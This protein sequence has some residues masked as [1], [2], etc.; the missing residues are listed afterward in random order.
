MSVIASFGFVPVYLG[1]LVT[2][3]LLQQAGRSLVATSSISAASEPLQEV[4]DAG[5]R[6]QQT[7][8]ARDRNSAATEVGG[9][10]GSPVRSGSTTAYTPYLTLSGSL[11]AYGT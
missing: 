2:G 4:I 9:P 11:A 3:G 5:D 6:M 8:Q 1:G 10:S 7:P